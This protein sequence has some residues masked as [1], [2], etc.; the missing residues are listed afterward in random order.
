MNSFWDIAAQV[1]SNALNFPERT[2]IKFGGASMTYR[3]LNAHI[4]SI[5][6]RLISLGVSRGMRVGLHLDRSPSMIAA[7]LA[8]HRIGAAYIPLDPAF[9]LARLEYIIADSGLQHLV[10]AG[11][12][13]LQTRSDLALDVSSIDFSDVVCAPDSVRC[14]LAPSDLA[15]IMYTSGSTGHPKGVMVHHGALCNFLEAMRIEPGLT[16]D[17]VLLAVTTPSFDISVLEIFLP[18]TVGAQIVLASNDDTMNG[19]ALAELIDTHNVTVMQATPATW[20]ML[21][22]AGWNGHANLKALCG[23]EA[24]DSALARRLTNVTASLWNMYGPTE[25]TV[26]STC[27]HI[28]RSSNLVHVGKPI[29]NTTVYLVDSEMR[30]V[31][32]GEIGELLIGGAGVAQGYTNE[33]LTAER[34]IEDH[35][36]GLPSARLYRTGDLARYR[37]DGTLEMLGRADDQVKVR[38][39]RIE[40]QEIQEH[41]AN[42][43]GVSQ[44]VIVCRKDSMGENELAAYLVLTSG[45][46]LELGEIRI[47][48]AST[49][50]HYMIPA[51]ISVLR[52][53]PLTPNGKVDRAALAAL[54]PNDKSESTSV[55]AGASPREVLFSLL[56]Q[57]LRIDTIDPASDLFSLGLSS[58]Q[59]NYVVSAFSRLSGLKASVADLFSNPSVDGFLRR[60]EA[61]DFTLSERARKRG[62]WE[63][64]AIAII[65]MAL[66]VPGAD[67]LEG[68]WRILASSEDTVTRFTE[69]EDDPTVENGVRQNPGYVRARGMI[70]NPELFDASLFGVSPNDAAVMDPQ[71]RVFLE[72]AWEALEN[73]AYDADRSG[74]IISVYAGMGNN[75]YYHYNVSTQP[76]LIE[77]VGDVQVEIGREKD[78][79]ATLVSHKLN[80]TGP[81][82][83]VHT[84]CS[85]GLVAVDSACHSL[86]SH[87]CDI[88]IAGAIELRT[89]QM[90][91]QVHEP[92]GIFTADGYCRLFSDDASGTMFSD[93]AGAIV[94]KRLSDAIADGDIIHSVIRGSAVNHDGSNKKSYLAPS[95]SGQMEVIATAQARAGVSPETIT[96]IEAHGTATPVGDPIEFEALRGVFASASANRNYC[97]LGSVKGNLGHPTTAAGIIGVI[98]TSLCLE[99]RTIVPL[100]NFTTINR[101]IDIDHSP[102]YIPK[103]ATPWIAHDA[104]R[105][106]GISSFGFCGTNAHV[107]MEEAP[108]RALSES[109][110]VRH[111][112]VMLMSAHSVRALDSIEQRLEK[113]LERSSPAEM[114]DAAFTLAIGRKRLKHRRFSVRHTTQRSKDAIRGSSRGPVT[115]LKGVAFV[116]PGQGS[117]YLGMGRGLY[118][119]EPVFREALDSCA[120]LLR[121]HLGCDIRE[122]M[123]PGTG[124][125]P[126]ADRSADKLD[127]TTFTQPAIFCLEYSLAKLWISWGVKPKVL[128]GHSIG[129][130]TC[131]VIA[132][133]MSLEDAIA[134]VAERGRL[135][136]DL[137]PGAM[138][139][140]R[141]PLEQVER[142]LG[143]ELSVAAINAPNLC[144]VAGR[145]KDIDD[146]KERLASDGT[147]CQRLKTSHAFHSWMMKDA[148]KPFRAIVDRVEL[149]RPQIDIISTVTGDIMS[150]NDAQSSDYW[151]DHLVNT[152]RFSD[153]I[154]RLCELGNFAILEVGPR[155]T[156]ST[157]AARITPAGYPSAIPSLS[158][159]SNDHAEQLAL[160][161]AIGQLWTSGI[162]MDWEAYFQ[163][164]NANRVQL[165]TYPFD[166]KRYWVEP[167]YARDSATSITAPHTPH[168]PHQHTADAETTLKSGTSDDQVIVEL[169]AILTDVSG[170]DMAAAS[171]HATFFEIGLDSLLLTP[172]TFL[173]KQRYG[174][175]VTF[176]QLS[177]ELSTLDALAAFI[178]AKL[179][180]AMPDAL[181]PVQNE[182]KRTE[183]PPTAGQLEIIHDA[184][185]DP[186][187][188]DLNLETAT[189]RLSGK[190]DQEA[191]KRAI[192]SVIARHEAL[193]LVVAEDTKS[194]TVKSV[195]AYELP[196]TY[197]HAHGRSLADLEEL[198]A[199]RGVDLFRELPIRFTFARLD[200]S[201]YHVLFITAHG[202]ACDGWSLDLIIEEIASLYTGAVLGSATSL[203]EPDSFL[204]FAE[205]ERVFLESEEGQY[206]RKFWERRPTHVYKSFRRSS[207]IAAGT[208]GWFSTKVLTE[209][210]ERDLFS[211]LKELAVQRR[212]SVFSVLFANYAHS[213]ME[214]TG[215][216]GILIGVPL[217]RQS[218]EHRHRLVGRC[219]NLVPVS[220]SRIEGAS[221]E[222]DLHLA[223]EALLEAH[224]N[225]KYPYDNILTHDGTLN[226]LTC[227][228][229]LVHVKRLK[230]SD[231]RFADLG[232]DYQIGLP[233][234]QKR[235]LTLN[236][237]EYED[238]IRLDGIF[239]EELIGAEDV[240]NI[241]SILQR[242]L[243]AMAALS[244]ETASVDGS[245]LAAAE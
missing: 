10:Y 11:S 95:I 91:G 144:V 99:R 31:P 221:V 27:G 191:L 46:V 6:S 200:D 45:A 136:G 55:A 148:V 179:S 211:K 28:D 85:T 71:Q 214:H 34:F 166:R 216:Q 7:M 145:D 244:V 198:E 112:E 231:A 219:V 154:V 183:I 58:L 153:A 174:V 139:S 131:A 206:Q 35:F 89:P 164:R 1:E 207:V 98:K 38:G 134:L 215:Q 194:M 187:A 105:R 81:S 66:R 39:H 13:R 232:V 133:V 160:A 182:K 226:G 115:S 224:E 217:A 102:F 156:M 110:I 227:D 155:R 51:T 238:N 87:Q 43:T 36:S 157:L 30:E 2:A 204:A 8:I 76:H 199:T 210:L 135:M 158:D 32:T 74:G 25:T 73:A 146:L 60:Q 109:P 79:I 176:R 59:A 137:P 80:L 72:V 21:L 172:V 169:R 229:A 82:I 127:Y 84:A 57:T 65:G 167:G 152:V 92:G 26:W 33:T 143:T 184:K 123:M 120:D 100:A 138:L 228:T 241:M 173:V 202:F 233:R 107:V 181:T 205:A 9:P 186:S 17:D 237:T 56:R 212:C 104:P 44:A 230:P 64:D 178:R 41:I 68:F 119:S 47:A 24:L 106:A 208:N 61:R 239:C 124:A 117:Q 197:I 77:M 190:L 129:E 49:L 235:A 203:A 63:N 150:A 163:N 114:N 42:I 132:G 185:N 192:S 170:E 236:I 240:I 86:L 78:H 128:I 103:T 69:A 162:E 101:N 188:I 29:L 161:T 130:F 149:R 234:K 122:T 70:R 53:L 40:L 140:V 209:T 171:A 196:F 193:R 177:S 151:A 90:S 5:S 175:A 12:S 195:G 141:A 225:G 126:F 19:A 52:Q 189:I 20:R 213:V 50:P 96:L 48:L 62:L 14:D 242:N 23:G 142:K 180:D 168:A 118:A 116:F 83:S 75:F 111:H 108:H 3:R 67:T 245:S 97:A 165:P 121:P 94:L 54:D 88:A 201:E 4:H 15:Y 113:F 218:I 93:G 220:Q 147:R 16:S 223:Y 222:R 18:L 243:R 22:A 159:T 37:A 125:I